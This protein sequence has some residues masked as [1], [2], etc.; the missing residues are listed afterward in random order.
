MLVPLRYLFD[1]PPSQSCYALSQL[2]WCFN[3]RGLGT[4][5]VQGDFQRPATIDSTGPKSNP[6]SSP[7][8]RHFEERIGSRSV[9]AHEPLPPRRCHR[10]IDP[11][12]ENLLV[13]SSAQSREN[14]RTKEFWCQTPAERPSVRSIAGSVRTG[15]TAIYLCKRFLFARGEESEVGIRRN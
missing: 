13:N 7:E 8:I 10:E 2:P 3:S 9:S 14:E 1:L 5:L 4:F 6:R 11:S 15:G 12:Q